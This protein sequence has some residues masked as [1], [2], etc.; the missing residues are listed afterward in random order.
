MSFLNIQYNESSEI[1]FHANLYKFHDTIKHLLKL[2]DDQW[3]YHD[4]YDL[5]IIFKNQHCDFL[6]FTLNENLQSFSVLL[7][8]N[9]YKIN[10]IDILKEDIDV[11]E[12][13]GHHY[14]DRKYLASIV[15]DLQ[16]K[17]NERYLNDIRAKSVD[18]NSAFS[19][20]RNI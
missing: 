11:N 12:F 6:T 1:A 10:Q 2:Y 19:G 4:T 18:K 13:K 14:N 17:A 9:K 5:S 3:K 8:F 20:K 16:I 7:E 15:L